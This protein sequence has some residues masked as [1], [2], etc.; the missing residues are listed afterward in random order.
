[1]LQKFSE[2]DIFREKYV[3]YDVTYTHKNATRKPFLLHWSIV[4]DS[5]T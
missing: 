3:T 1:M 5:L 4:W 2:V